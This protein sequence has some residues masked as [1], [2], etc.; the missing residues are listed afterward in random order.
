MYV[1]RDSR[2]AGIGEDLVTA[3]L[4]QARDLVDLVTLIFQQAVTA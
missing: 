4:D 2:N 1:N 3:I